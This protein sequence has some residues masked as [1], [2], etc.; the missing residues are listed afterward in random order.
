MVFYE[1]DDPTNTGRQLVV[2]NPKIKT[3]PVESRFKKLG[4]RF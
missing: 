3:R 2:K 1:P 4:Y